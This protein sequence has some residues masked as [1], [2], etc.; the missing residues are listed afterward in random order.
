MKKAENIRPTTNDDANKL[1]LTYCGLF[2][3]KNKL[4]LKKINICLPRNYLLIFFK[5]CPFKPSF[6]ILAKFFVHNVLAFSS[7]SHKSR[8][9]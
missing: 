8:D 5:V 3:K 4:D 6:E 7:L 2:V 1:L 9:K